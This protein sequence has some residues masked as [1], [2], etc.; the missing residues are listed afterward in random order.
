MAN[1]WQSSIALFGETLL[2]SEIPPSI[3]P[4]NLPAPHPLLGMLTVAR[5]RTEYFLKH[6]EQPCNKNSV[7]WPEL[8]CWG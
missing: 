8:P 4:A 7:L 3:H 6:S 2:D 1:S 5:S